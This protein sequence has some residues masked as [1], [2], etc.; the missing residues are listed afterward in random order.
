MLIRLFLMAALI[1]GVAP[2]RV[3]DSGDQSNMDD[4]RQVVVRTAAE[5]NALWRLHAPERPQPTVNFSAEMVVGVFIGSRPSAGFAVEILGVEDLGGATVVRY[6]ETV[7]G[8]QAVT[9]Q[10]I[11][12][13][14]Q[15][16]AVPRRAGE[17][18][19]EKQL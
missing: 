19:F 1:Q 12:S 4:G 13:A 18:R 15:L 17:V 7:P 5:L 10:V 6:R 16:V 11:T 2:L 14:Y 3:L 9:A 8:R